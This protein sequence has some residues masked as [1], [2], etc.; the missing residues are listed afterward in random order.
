MTRAMGLGPRFNDTRE[1]YP[2]MTENGQVATHLQIMN[3][4][5]LDCYELL[6][7]SALDCLISQFCEGKN[8][9]ILNFFI[10]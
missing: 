6:Y 4:Q 10:Y 9:N 7:Y 2:L 3:N 1:V 5:S 8:E